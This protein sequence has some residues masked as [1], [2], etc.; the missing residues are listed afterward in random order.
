MEKL[1]LEIRMEQALNGIIT[2]PI[3]SLEDP[4]FTVNT[5]VKA[6]HKRHINGTTPF[7]RGHLRNSIRICIKNLM[8][9]GKVLEESRAYRLVR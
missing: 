1:P 2:D 6:L 9:H 5:V 7:A 8:E 3:L 4:V